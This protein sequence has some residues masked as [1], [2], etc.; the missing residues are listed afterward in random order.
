[1]ASGLPNPILHI[2]IDYSLITHKLDILTDKNIDVGT[3]E[4]YCNVV[5]I[6]K[7]D[8]PHYTAFPI[9]CYYGNT[10]I[11]KFLKEKFDLTKE[12][13]DLPPPPTRRYRRLCLA[14]A[15]EGGHLET[16]KWLCNE[17]KFTRE[18]CMSD[19]NYPLSNSLNRGH[20]DCAEYLATRTNLRLEE[21]RPDP[22]P[23]LHRFNDHAVIWL[24]KW[25]KIPEDKQL[26]FW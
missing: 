13:I 4:Q 18:D 3:L 10:M 24:N 14:Y 8:L 21:C 20:F 16:M 25:F 12:D 11:L 19:D 1:M 5:N 6:I 17:F 15:G 22:W 7:D 2:I 9:H 23:Y 26:P